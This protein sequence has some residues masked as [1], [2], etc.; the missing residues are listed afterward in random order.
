MIVMKRLSIYAAML[1]LLAACTK[2]TITY[3]NPVPGENDKEVIAQ[4][5]VDSRNTLFSSSDDTHASVAF[6]SVGGEVVIDVNTNVEWDCKVSG[7]E[8]VTAVKDAE[9][10]QLLLSCDANKSEKK[11]S[12]SVEITAG[13][14]SVSVAVTQNAYGT[15]EITASQNNFHI[16]AVGELKAG[17]TVT[18]SDEDWTFETVAC[19][20]MFVE[21]NGNEL[22]LTIDPNVEFSDRETEITLIAGTGSNGPVTEKIAV[23]QD[24]AAN[25][26]VGAQ[27]IPFAPTADTEKEVFVSANF[28]WD[29][30]LDNPDNGWLVVERTETGLK[31]TPKVNSGEESRVVTITVRTGDGKENIAEKIITVSQTGM[32]LNAFIVGLNV[33]AKDL[34]S[35]LFFGEGFEGTIDWGDGTVEEVS[36]DTYPSHTYTDP[37][38]YIVSAKG[39]A[40]A[41]YVQY[42]SY[43]NQKDQL[44]RVYNWGRLGVEYMDEAFRQ[45]KNLTTIPED[46]CEAFKNVVS[47]EYAFAECGITEIPEGLL[48]Y[49]ENAENVDYLFYSTK[50][51]TSVPKGLLYNCPK[52]E[53]VKSMLALTEISSIDKDF[54]SRN[55]EITDVSQMFSTCKK[56]TSIPQGFFD[57]NPKITTCNALFA[58]CEGLTSI[59]EGLFDK[60]TACTT[61]R[62]AFHTTGITAIPA[63]LFKNNTACTTF[64]NTFNGTKITSIPEDIFEGCSKVTQFRSCFNGCSELKSIPAG[65]FTKTGATGNNL[66]KAAFTMVFEECTSLE[67]IPAGL[68]DGFTKIQQFNS[69]FADC[70]SLKSV[71][72]GLFSSCTNV[73]QMTS[74]FAGCTSLTEVPSEFFKGLAKVTSFASMFDGCTGLLTVGS[75]IFSGCVACTSISGLFKG[76]TS[77]ESVSETAFSGLA[78]VTSIANLFQN[79]SSLKTVPAG[80]FRDM[81]GITNASNVFSGS[82]LISTPSGLFSENARIT[83]FATAFK[84]CESLVTVADGL[85]DGASGATSFKSAFEGCTALETVGNIFGTSTVS[86]NIACDLLFKGCVSLKSV[87]SGLFDGLRTVNTFVSAFEGCSSL[88]SIPSGLF[89]NQTAATSL[90]L[91]KCF[92]GCTSLQSVPDDLFGT[93]DR[94]NIT[95]CANM[96]EKCTS[97]SSVATNSFKVLKRTS[98]TSLNNLFDGCTSIT[99]V[100]AGLFKET[101]G[102][103]SNVFKGCTSLRSV[104]SE[105][106]NGQRPTGL[107][108]LFV[109]C[110]ALTDVSASMFC[111]VSGV[112]SL[113]GIFS[114]CTSL[115][116]VPSGLFDGMTKVTTM[117]SLFKDCTSLTS[118]SKALFKDQTLVT[119]VNGMFSGCTGLVSFPVDFFDE[120]VKITNVGNLFNGCV[121]ITGESPYTV[122]NGKKIHIYE[123][124]NTAETGMSSI[125]TATSSRKGCFA[126]CTGMTDYAS[127]PDAWK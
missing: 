52:L 29:Y 79:C 47:F 10:D 33:V 119:N 100:P 116:T 11:L 77:L 87:P 80:L 104:G 34:T 56:L 54:L 123:R 96:F 32:D 78:K 107:T 71:P 122:V 46:N 48:D 15:L 31:V 108:N 73:T 28:D 62:M 30:S 14:K 24:R 3:H 85:F 124:T 4:L 41:I 68:F 113:A 92:S 35:I 12:A 53:S 67:E 76:C 49:A 118:V 125:A 51:I 127:I 7:D 43:Y 61:F 99:E 70:T 57:N 120:M 88:A 19:E 40:P 89:A 25:I 9:S 55:P 111:D 81:T 65:L 117:S 18:S 5:G 13:D 95:T 66:D 105:V 83:N 39:S 58:Y 90:T 36:T 50:G 93:A 102:T 86:A 72:S 6:K 1:L 97:I 84:G 16:P 112:T 101:I 17:F 98:G 63:G 8:F 27:T 75:D 114:G 110:T 59:P 37:A 42:G 64:D 22:T 38:E 44:V 60:L 26:S 91:Q 121:N 126:G 103:F 82:G 109:N 106:F 94:T 69:I 45:C 115:R 2:E 74:A 23:L 20:W 21:R